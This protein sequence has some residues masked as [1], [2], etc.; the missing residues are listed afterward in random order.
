MFLAKCSTCLVSPEKIASDDIC[1]MVVTSVGVMP[2]WYPL[3][4]VFL[5][6]IYNMVIFEG[7]DPP[8]PKLGRESLKNI[9]T[10]R[11]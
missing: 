2:P 6:F 4:I 5:I 10:T 7:P 11:H 8:T 3:S 9:N 1:I